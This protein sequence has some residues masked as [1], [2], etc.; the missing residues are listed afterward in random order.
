MKQE[1][2]TTKRQKSSDTKKQRLTLEQKQELKLKRQKERE[3]AKGDEEPKNKDRFYCKNN[4]MRLELLKWRNSDK[5]GLV[6]QKMVDDKLVKTKSFD[7][8][9]QH[10]QHED[11]VRYF[12]KISK[13]DALANEYTKKLVEKA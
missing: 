5:K 2:K 13:E 7:T 12:V 9:E 10:E 4:D 6:V 8:P 11:G 1:Q 3:A